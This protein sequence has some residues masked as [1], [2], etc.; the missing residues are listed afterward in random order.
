MRMGMTTDWIN[1]QAPTEITS[2]SHYREYRDNQ[3]KEDAYEALLQEELAQ[4]IVQKV[5][6]AYVRCY[7][8]S[9]AVLKPSRGDL[10]APPKYR[11]VLDARLVNFF[12]KNIHFK[13]EG[14]ED[15]FALALIGDWA[16]SLDL[17]SAFN[18][19]IVHKDLR[20]FLGFAFRGQS[21]VYRAMPFGT[22]HAQ[23]L[24]TKALS[25]AAAFIR[26]HWDIRMIV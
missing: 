21:Y 6:H 23:R 15:I 3:E 20:P 10:S 7:N 25:F 12:Q 24:F 1:D 9:F 2:K 22:K 13:M 26:R 16:T 18:H 11:K 8:H 17:K 4:K 5:N 14:P 19:L